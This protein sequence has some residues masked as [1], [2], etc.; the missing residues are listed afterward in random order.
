MYRIVQNTPRGRVVLESGFINDG[1]AMSRA[2]ILRF[3]CDVDI[4]LDIESY[5][6]G[7]IF[8]IN[9][10]VQSVLEHSAKLIAHGR[11]LRDIDAGNINNGYDAGTIE[12]KEYE[13][14]IRRFNNEV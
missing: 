11:A 4:D 3:D 2:N 8:P 6:D 10:R 1:A 9:S 14:T 13:E 7:N 12:H 5:V